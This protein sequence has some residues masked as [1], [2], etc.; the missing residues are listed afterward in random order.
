VRRGCNPRLVF[1]TSGT[2]GSPVTTLWTNDELRSSVALREARSL[3]WA[4]CSLNQPRATFSGRIVEPDA[5]SNGPFYRYNVVERQVYFSVFHL[6]AR[7][8]PAYVRAL[9]RHR[10]E[11]L[12]GFAVTLW[13]LARFIVELGLEVPP[14]RAVVTTSEKVT[15]A[16]RET[17]RRAYRCPVFEEY[18]SVENTLFAS[19]CEA[20]SLHVSPDSG[21]VEILRPD[22]TPCPI[23]EPGEVVATGLLRDAHPLIRYRQGDMAA[24]RGGVCSCGRALPMLEGVYG[25]TEDLLISP[26]GRVMLRFDRV[27]DLP[28]VREGQVVQETLARIRVN[29]VPAPGFSGEDRREIVRRVQQRMGNEVEVAVEL[30]DGIARTKAGKFPAVVSLLPAAERQRQS[31]EEAHVP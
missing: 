11:W 22:G 15:P 21:I 9:A 4:G 18:S 31:F 29:V 30:V 14:L 25:R 23:G 28:A 16:M 2:T 27:F 8:A 13:L 5:R 3:R 10:S 12:N 20:G 7:T 6:S 17:M 26:S 19:E 24:W 1:T